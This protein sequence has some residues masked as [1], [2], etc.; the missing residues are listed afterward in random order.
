MKQIS[1]KWKF[2]LGASALALALIALISFVQATF[3]RR[4]IIE[5]VS[6]QQFALATRVAQDLDADLNFSLAAIARSAEAMPRHLLTNP[7]K[8]RQFYAER[9]AMLMLFSDILLVGADGKVISDQPQIDGRTAIDVSDRKYFKD[10]MATSKPTISEPVLSKLRHEPIINMGAPITG[11]D[12]KV[13]AVLTGVMMLNR[14]NILSTL[15]STK[16]GKAGYC[17]V[18][19]KGINPIYIVHPDQSRLL[20]PRSAY[21]N[22]KTA[23]AGGEF[24]GSV[25]GTNGDGANATFSYKSLTAVNW[26][27]GVVLP[28]D[29]AYA[30]VAAAERRL[31]AI[32]I[33][34]AMLVTPLLWMLAWRVLT[35]LSRMRD[36]IRNM[37]NEP[38]AFAPVD[39]VHD[40]EIGEL[41]KSFNTLMQ[42]REDAQSS[43]RA[44]EKFLQRTGDVA[45][46]GGW[47][48]DIASKVITWSDVTCRLHDVSPGYHPT[49]AEAIQF[50]MPE[51]RPAIQAAFERALVTGESWDL[52]L[53]LVSAKGRE[54]WARAVGS[55]E[56]EGAK[57]VR[58][59]GAFQDITARKE[60]EIALSENR[61]LLQVTLDSIGDAVITTDVG[62]R[63]VWLNPIAERMTGWLK[64][65]ARDRPLD[66][67]FVIVH[68]LTRAPVQSPVTA[69]LREGKIVALANHTTL[70]SRD[71]SEYGIEDSAAPIRG[72]VG[73][74]LGA[75]LVF[76][77]VSE[78]RR[79]GNEMTHRATH[80][81][82]TG[83]PNRS[84]FETRL[85]QL[86]IRTKSD[87]SQ[88]A[89]LYIDLDQ[90]KLVND[91][92]GH[93]VGDQ[94]LRQVSALLRS[95]VRHCDT[96]A[97]LGGDEFGAILDHCD[98]EHAQRVAQQI[99]DRLEEFR[100]LHD[101]RRYRIG[102]SIGMVPVDKRWT[103]VS[104]ILQAAD[105]SCYAAK[106]AGR[107]RVHVWF[108]TDQAM[109]ARHSEMQWITRLEQ[110]LDENRFELYGQRIE[111]MDGPHG[112]QH[113]EVLL[114]LR[115]ASGEIILPGAFLPAAERYNLAT[116]IDRWVVRK[117]FALMTEL[118]LGTSDLGMVAV[119]LSGQSIG[120][121]AFQRDICQMI[122]LAKFD[123]HKLCFE[124][125]ETAAITCIAEA[126]VFINDV[127]KLGVCIAL[128]DFGAG[129]SSFGYLKMLPVDYLKIDGQF[130]TH[131]LDDALDN[132]AVRCFRDV[133]KVV[134]V[135]TIAEFVERDD[136]RQ[137][138]REIGIDMA[139]GYLIHRPEPLANLLQTRVVEAEV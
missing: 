115:E 122:K 32:A 57:P 123:V 10:V 80:D 31:M 11:P 134:G 48:F 12:G 82:L 50:Y 85:G 92:C 135:K 94:L 128:D 52:E 68:E 14:S 105:T 40:D 53:R 91:A 107:N 127:R 117:V 114:R 81:A 74:V 112:E 17:F 22:G 34:V 23:D 136:V 44:S 106:E 75:V 36:A 6:T 139:Q 108:D 116:R 93:S 38:I 35:P 30:P 102:T 120:D 132:A 67:V 103:S 104:A 55:R 71:G 3:L 4:D 129:A 125:T 41:A 60:A 86:L 77:D 5:L 131:L 89:V 98:V 99:C 97:R 24:E 84:E 119:N 42:Q 1:I 121:L 7:E 8:F 96:V 56:F 64:S 95:C 9:P 47:E 138:L 100:F 25:E 19:T 70:I 73:K 28:H 51:A 133:A 43:Q 65:E 118:E 21:V 39:I 78:K 72:D 124:I 20:K 54:F 29:E 88:S 16:V 90:F 62:G 110:A 2:A 27:L 111:P 130:I 33:V 49:L 45:G 66:Q 13:L 58:L 59:V 18:V 113:L 83:L 137:S 37:S 126:K 63:V 61:E 87:Q 76:H 69:C 15:G 46:V 26:M 79:L 109:Q 101:D